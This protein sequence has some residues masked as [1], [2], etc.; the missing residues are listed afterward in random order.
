MS[1]IHPDLIRLVAQVVRATDD[2]VTPQSRFDSLDNW[3]S[4]T[5]LR[6]LT[7]I[8]QRWGVAFDL[9]R[10]FAVETVGELAEQLEAARR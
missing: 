6:L 10:Y 5:A 8:E 7:M 9:R 4:L 2:E 1:E 3:T